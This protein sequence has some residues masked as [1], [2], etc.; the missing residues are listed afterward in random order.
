MLPAV[1]SQLVVIV[2]DTALGG[3]LVGYVELRRAAN[4]SASAY[5][6]LAA[7]VR[8]C[9][10]HLHRDQRGARLPLD[11]AGAQA[12]HPPRRRPG[13]AH[14]PGRADGPAATRQEIEVLDVPGV[15]E[16]VVRR[17]RRL[18]PAARPVAGADHLLPA[19]T[20][21]TMVVTSASR[22]GTL[23]ALWPRGARVDRSPRRC[24]SGRIG[25]SPPRPGGRRRPVQRVAHTVEPRPS[26]API[27]IAPCADE[28]VDSG[29][30]SHKIENMIRARRTDPILRGNGDR[31]VSGRSRWPATRG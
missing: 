25:S 4:T 15:D 21:S 30:T 6:N 22:S 29:P 2:K 23:A 17:V 12:A 14:R 7:D 5:S 19:R 3:I 28:V 10:A 13:R 9:R 16:T 24:S 11:V 18:P 31:S 27:V 1:V 26:P 20:N 8:R